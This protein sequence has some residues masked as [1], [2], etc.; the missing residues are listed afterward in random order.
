M[1]DRCIFQVKS[2]CTGASVQLSVVGC[3]HSGVEVSLL[4]PKRGNDFGVTDWAGNGLQLEESI[5]NGAES[6]LT[7]DVPA[8]GHL[9]CPAPA[10]SV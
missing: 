9:R 8:G 10:V 3:L 6:Y 2:R 1:I 5:I 7:N 4:R